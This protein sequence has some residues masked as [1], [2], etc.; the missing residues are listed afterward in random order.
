MKYAAVIHGGIQL[1]PIYSKIKE[2]VNSHSGVYYD[3]LS[4]V[5]WINGKTYYHRV[6]FIHEEDLLAF[7]LTF[8][9]YVY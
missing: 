5:S 3:M 8:A 7:K 2:W 9:G 1:E 4:G 6:H